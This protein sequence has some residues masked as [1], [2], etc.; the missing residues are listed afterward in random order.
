M[1]GIVRVVI[2]LTL[3]FTFL[4]SGS[5]NTQ[6][7]PESVHSSAFPVVASSLGPTPTNC[8]TTNLVIGGQPPL[9]G[10]RAGGGALVGWSM[11]FLQDHRATLPVGPRVVYGWPQKIFWQL[12]PGAHGPVHLYGW[13]LRTRAPIWF[14]HPV[15]PNPD[16]HFIAWSS[17]LIR[18]HHAPDLTF[19]PSAGCYGLHA[20]WNGGDWT[21]YFAVGSS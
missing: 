21:L 14:G 19:V 13:N 18:L 5:T 12:S 3:V 7:A 1:L 10:G 8:P 20:Q 11:W 15:L 2:G 16:H 9:H 6:A 4:L 17:A